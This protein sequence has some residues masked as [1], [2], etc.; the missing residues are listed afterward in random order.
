M[1]SRMEVR[2]TIS[3]L[4]DTGKTPKE[5][6]ATLG[7]SRA[8]VFKVKKIKSTGGDLG[9]IVT[10]CRKSVVTPTVRPAIKKKIHAN[11]KKSLTTKRR[12]V[13]RFLK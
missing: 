9:R 13:G 4:V 6:V 7:C 1:S 10:A 8:L 12:N 3:G 5:I 11:P 2:H